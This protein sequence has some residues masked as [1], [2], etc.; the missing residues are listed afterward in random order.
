MTRLSGDQNGKAPPSVPGS[1]CAVNESRGSGPQLR[2]LPNDRSQGKPA[3][4]VGRNCAAGGCDH[5]PQ[6]ERRT[7]NSLRR[8]MNEEASHCRRGDRPATRENEQASQGGDEKQPGDAFER[9]ALESGDSRC[10]FSSG[11]RLGRDP[12]GRRRCRGNVACGSF[13]RHRCSSRRTAVG[14]SAGSP[15]NQGPSSG[16]CK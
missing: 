7:E 2:L 1:G 11:L 10:Y 8:W 13:S 6:R 5:R 12:A 14:V 4:S 15:P 9:G 3:A 16:C